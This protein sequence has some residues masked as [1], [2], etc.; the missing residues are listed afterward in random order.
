MVTCFSEGVIKSKQKFGKQR[1]EIKNRMLPSE[2]AAR[3]NSEL[4]PRANPRWSNR[5][6]L[7][8][9]RKA[10]NSAIKAESGNSKT[11]QKSRKQKVEIIS[12]L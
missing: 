3:W 10:E 11:K 9:A 8:G 2:V 4:I 5:S 6:A 1:V 12:V 7:H